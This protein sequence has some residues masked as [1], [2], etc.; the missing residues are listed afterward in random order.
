[1]MGMMNQQHHPE[2]TY[3]PDTAEK[4]QIA[5]LALLKMMK[6]CRA[7]VP[8]EVM[9][10][11]LGE[12]IDEYT[13]EVVD[14]FAMPQLQ[15]TVSVEAI[16]PAYQ[17]NM[18]E[19]LKVIGQQAVA[20]G[21]YHSH[22]GY[23]CW[24]SAVDVQTQKAFER[25]GERSVAVVV[26]PVQ[27]TGGRVVMDAFRSIPMNLMAMATEP[28]ITTSNIYHIKPKAGKMARLRGLDKLFYNMNIDSHAVEENE[29]NML[30][31]LRSAHWKTLLQMFE[32]L[33]SE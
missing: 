3:I 29:V 20:V 19:K 2:L 28:R 27:S 33:P 32:P 13:I 18:L 1:M 24:L 7:G 30:S 31:K 21:W 17:A 5:P 11:L 12:F 26:D 10:V 25:M 22:P 14:V 4:V 6:H 8:F 23:G 9:G 15:T 16:D